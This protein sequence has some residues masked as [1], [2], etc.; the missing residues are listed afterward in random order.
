MTERRLP[1]GLS[2]RAVADRENIAVCGIHTWGEARAA[3]Y[4]AALDRA[5]DNLSE[6]PEL[7]GVRNGLRAGVRAIPAGRHVVYYASRRMRSK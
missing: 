1:I 6:H 5:I 3:T 7:G 2:D 4:V